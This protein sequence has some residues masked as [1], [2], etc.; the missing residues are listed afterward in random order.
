MEATATQAS[1]A[2][3]PPALSG[4]SEGTGK[5]KRRGLAL[6]RPDASKR[7][8]HDEPFLAHPDKNLP[9][10]PSPTS[11]HGATFNL[12]DVLCALLLLEDAGSDPNILELQRHDWQVSVDEV[13]TVLDETRSRASWAKCPKEPLHHG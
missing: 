7:P 8:R 6:P 11:L 9:T 3:A 10:N 4:P 2:P 13:Q 12:A 5:K 1:A